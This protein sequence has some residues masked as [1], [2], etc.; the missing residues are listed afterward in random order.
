[1]VSSDAV[2]ERT[3]RSTE[4][5]GDGERTVGGPVADED[6]DGTA[7]LAALRPT[8][9]ELPASAKLVATV[10]AHEGAL[11]GTG[12]AEETRLPART[13]RYALRRL[14]AADAVESGHA[15]RDAR[16]RIYRLQP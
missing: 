14:E 8:L 11:T 13:V 2:S 6:P 4:T 16:K 10:L 1:M 12:I 3:A 9:S 7:A 15:L 5:A